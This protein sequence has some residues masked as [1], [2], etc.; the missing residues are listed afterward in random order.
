MAV[1]TDMSNAYDRFEWN[2]IRLVFKKLG[3]DP[4]WVNWVMQ[5]IST[6]SYS[7]LVNDSA[8]GNVVPIRGIRQGD[9][10]SLY[11]F[12]ICGE[13][14]SGVFRLGQSS[15]HLTRVKIGLH[16][17]RIDHLLFAD[18]TMIFTKASAENCTFLTSILRDYERASGQ[19]INTAKSSISFSSKTPQATRDRV[20]LILGIEKEGGVGKYL[21][22][23]ELFTR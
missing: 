6:V 5:C 21:G 23:P 9:P 1:K 7:F 2:F 14:L 22:L 13:V 12:I 19:L 17:P 4:I 8:L 16:C 15:G 18:D 10:L 20:K 11:I 3:F